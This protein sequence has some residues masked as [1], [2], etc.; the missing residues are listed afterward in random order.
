MPGAET[1]ACHLP[2][3]VFALSPFCEFWGSA[4]KRPIRVTRPSIPLNLQETAILIGDLEYMVKSSDLQEKAC[5]K[6]L[7][8]WVRPSVFKHF[9]MKPTY[10]FWMSLSL[11]NPLQSHCPFVPLVGKRCPPPSSPYVLVFHMW[12]CPHLVHVDVPNFRSAGLCV[13]CFVSH[14]H[15]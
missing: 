3:T 4:L 14:G 2:H 8:L 1:A 13:C 9:D 7:C 15:F 11:S 10:H 12:A 6:G 5:D